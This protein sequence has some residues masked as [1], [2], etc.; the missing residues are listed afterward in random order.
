MVDHNSKLVTRKA[1]LFLKHFHATEKYCTVCSVASIGTF[2]SPALEC[3]HRQNLVLFG[4]AVYSDFNKVIM[5]QA[6]RSQ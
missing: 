3:T 1:T 4:K 2:F 5:A 6:M